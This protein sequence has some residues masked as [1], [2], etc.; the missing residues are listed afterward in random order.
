MSNNIPRK[1]LDTGRRPY[2]GRT[3][4]APS[5]AGLEP[6]R[7]DVSLHRGVWIT[8]RVMDKA[9]GEGV[10]VYVEYV[11]FRENPHADAVESSWYHVITMMSGRRKAFFARARTSERACDFIDGVQA[12]RRRR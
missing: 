9:T 10:H 6:I 11:P 4:E 1:R 7:L 2:F 8:G 5:T 12:G 3:F